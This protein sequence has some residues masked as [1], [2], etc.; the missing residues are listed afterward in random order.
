MSHP[1]VALQQSPEEGVRGWRGAAAGQ[2]GEGVCARG[3]GPR[4]STV[5]GQTK[6]SRPQ[7]P[8]AVGQR[9]EGRVRGRERLLPREGEEKGK[10]P[11]QPCA[12]RV[13]RRRRP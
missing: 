9:Q 12:L 1:P 5:S 8:Q 11:G 13:G 3:R 4:E 10:S 6:K 2:A 7:E